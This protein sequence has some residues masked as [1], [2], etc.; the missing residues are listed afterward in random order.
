MKAVET[1]EA[2]NDR[3]LFGTVE[4]IADVMVV[5]F[6]LS[7]LVGIPDEQGNGDASTAARAEDFAAFHARSFA[8]SALIAP[9][10]EDVD[11]GELIGKAGANSVHGVTVNERAIGD[12]ADNTASRDTVASPSKSADIAD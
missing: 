6:A 11:A 2:T 8:R 4:V 5:E 1:L 7:A 9:K 10:V 12:K 3:Q